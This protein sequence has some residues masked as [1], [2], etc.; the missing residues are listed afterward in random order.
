MKHH[1]AFLIYFGAFLV[2]S[3][4]CAAWPVFGVSADLILVLSILFP[5]CYGGWQGAVLGI[6]FGLV[7]DLCSG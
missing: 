3:T 1:Y 2:Q 6:F 4:F 7:R 5:F